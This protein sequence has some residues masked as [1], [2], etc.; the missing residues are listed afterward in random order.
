LYVFPL[1]AGWSGVSISN[2]GVYG[3]TLP[4][5]SREEALAGCARSPRETD[6]EDLFHTLVAELSAYFAGVRVGL[7][8]PVDLDGYSA[9]Q[10]HVLRGLTGISWGDTRTYGE[11]AAAVGSPRGARAVGQACGANRIPLIIPCHRVTA[12]GGGLGGFGGGLV[13]KRRLLALEGTRYPDRQCEE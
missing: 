7:K 2:R 9:F 5:P 13:W 8:F 10:Q 3:L 1:P 6:D 4:A 12:A 11:V